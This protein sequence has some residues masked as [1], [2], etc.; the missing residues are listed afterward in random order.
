[1]C[2]SHRDYLAFYEV[3]VHENDRLRFWVFV[4][5]IES[6]FDWEINKSR[7]LQR[8]QFGIKRNTFSH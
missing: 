7:S 3:F 6:L 8:Q 2:F 5:G 4:S 1:M